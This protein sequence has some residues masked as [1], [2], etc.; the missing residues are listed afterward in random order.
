MFFEG[1]GEKVL[2][3]ERN[4]ISHSDLTER[5]VEW[6]SSYLPMALRLPIARAWGAARAP[7]TPGPSHPKTM[8][9]T[10]FLESTT[11][12]TTMKRK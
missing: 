8:T 4:I 11:W 12:K 3:C 7:G 5:D 2:G 1:E 9:E 10:T 6:L